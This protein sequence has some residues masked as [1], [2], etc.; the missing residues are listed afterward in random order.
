MTLNLDMGVG[1]VTTQTEPLEQGQ[2]S[3]KLGPSP[4]EQGSGPASVLEEPPHP[5]AL[6]HAQSQSWPASHT[7]PAAAESHLL[8]SPADFLTT[9][10]IPLYSTLALV[11]RSRKCPHRRLAIFS[12]GM[13]TWGWWEPQGGCPGASSVSDQAGGLCPRSFK[14]A[15]RAG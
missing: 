11:S 2:Y 3:L 8:F 9:S 10:N 15:L 5:R 6:E 4:L 14:F 1:D 13:C 12:S 7:G